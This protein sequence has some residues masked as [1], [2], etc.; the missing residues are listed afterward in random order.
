[1]KIAP[2]KTIGLILKARGPKTTVLLRGISTL[3]FW[4]SAINFCESNPFKSDRGDY[5][6]WSRQ[7][8]VK[9]L[10][11]KAQFS[12]SLSFALTCLPTSALCFAFA[13][14][15]FVV[16]P[17]VIFDAVRLAIPSSVRGPVERPPWNL[18]RP[19]VL[20]PG[21]WQYVPFRVRASHRVPCQFGP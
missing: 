8:L 21:R 6:N 14:S 5:L 12:I 2:I 11:S 7:S 16:R 15:V 19:L 10:W 3:V 13:R 9:R 20:L 18:H 17:W 4:L 1:M